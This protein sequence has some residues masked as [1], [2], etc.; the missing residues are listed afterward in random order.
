M[1]AIL[2]TRTPDAPTVERKDSHLSVPRVT[3]LANRAY[4]QP[5]RQRIVMCQCLLQPAQAR[6]TG[7]MG[8]H[9]YFRQ[10]RRRNPDL[11]AYGLQSATIQW[12]LC[13]LP[14]WERE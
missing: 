8:Q 3:G 12:L 9:L 2:R 11:I 6:V 10:L 1:P 14:S 7:A 13:R 5:P 4:V